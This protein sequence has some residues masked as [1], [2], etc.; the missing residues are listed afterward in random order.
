MTQVTNGKNA[1]PAFGGRLSDEGSTTSR[2]TSSTRRTATSGTGGARRLRLPG[3]VPARVFNC[4]STIFLDAPARVVDASG[5]PAAR[6]MAGGAS[7]RWRLEWLAL[8]SR[9]AAPAGCAWWAFH[10]LTGSA[11]LRQLVAVRHSDHA[12]TTTQRP[13]RRTRRSFFR[14]R[15][16]IS[17]QPHPYPI[18]SKRDG[19]PQWPAGLLESGACE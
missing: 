4:R 14:R 1:M 9:L 17:L 15:A 12:S 19:R 10:L 2:R 8:R 5:R 3:G 18:K 7:R 16:A 11:V 6:R 13:E